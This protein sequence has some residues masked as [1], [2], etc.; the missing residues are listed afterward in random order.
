MTYFEINSKRILHKTVR[1][2]MST[3]FAGDIRCDTQCR[4]IQSTGFDSGTIQ[5]KLGEEN[6]KKKKKK[7]VAQEQVTSRDRHDELRWLTN[8]E[9][10]WRSE[11]IEHTGSVSRCSRNREF[12]QRTTQCLRGNYGKRR[13]VNKRV[14]VH[15]RPP[16]ER[17][18]WFSDWG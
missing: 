2:T 7:W 9:S 5:P 13:G 12:P 16:G 1:N 10:V 4:G 6:K 18:R 14:C 17:N 8:R 15:T 3:V 11:S